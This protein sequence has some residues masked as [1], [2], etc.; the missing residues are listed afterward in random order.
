MVSASKTEG[1]RLD[2]K[3]GLVCRRWVLY[4]SGSSAQ[5]LIALP[6]HSENSER[7]TGDPSGC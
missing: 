1:C 2:G 6:N 4:L 3:E 5:P 7:V